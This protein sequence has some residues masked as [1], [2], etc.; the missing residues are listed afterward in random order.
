MIAGPD[1]DGTATGM[2]IAVGATPAEATC[3][4]TP[5][6]DFA[7]ESPS[8]A[9]ASSTVVAGSTVAAVFTEADATKR[10]TLRS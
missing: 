1:A 3:I 10:L 8:T 6:M 2:R 9:E 7:V 5:A 4:T